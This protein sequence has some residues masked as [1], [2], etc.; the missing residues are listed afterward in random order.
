MVLNLRTCDFYLAFDGL[1][2][3]KRR[4]K[5]A[6]TTNDLG[7]VYKCAKKGRKNGGRNVRKQA[8]D[9]MIS[10]LDEHMR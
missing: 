7:E 1:L 10:F 5:T 8:A 3:E 4:G 6:R 9:D 2:I